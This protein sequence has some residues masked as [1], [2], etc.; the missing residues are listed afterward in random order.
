MIVAST[1][2]LR[3]ASIAMF[4]LIA[5][6]APLVALRARKYR[7]PALAILLYGASYETLLA[8]WSWETYSHLGEPVGARL[9]FT[10]VSGAF[11]LLTMAE[12]WRHNRVEVRRQ[13]HTAKTDRAAQNL[14]AEVERRRRERGTD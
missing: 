6:W 8:G 12:L 2:W 9:I 4:M 1:D 7:A 11:G 3:Y 5:L 10:L 14:L 13:R